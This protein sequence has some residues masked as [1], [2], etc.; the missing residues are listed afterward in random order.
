MAR[1]ISAEQRQR[2]EDDF[3]RRHGFNVWDEGGFVHGQTIEQQAEDVRR[4]KEREA[5]RRRRRRVPRE[6]AGAYERSLK[7]KER[8]QRRR[9]DKYYRGLDTY[10]DFVRDQ[11]RQD[12]GYWERMRDDALAAYDRGLMD[13]RGMRDRSLD[14][15]GRGMTRWE[16]ALGIERDFLTGIRDQQLSLARELRDAPSTVAEQARIEADRALQQNV[17]MAGAFGGGAVSNFGALANQARTAQGDVLA[18]TSALRASEY[19]NR[20]NQQANILGQ[21]GGTSIDL[22]NLG[23]RDLG[24]QTGYAGFLSDTGLRDLTAGQQYAGFLKGLGTT[25]F[26]IGTSLINREGGILGGLGDVLGFG[27]RGDLAFLDR[28]SQIPGMYQNIGQQEYDIFSKERAWQDMMDQREAQ[29]ISGLFKGIANIATGG[30]FD[31]IGSLFGGGRSMSMPDIQA[32]RPIGGYSPTFG[33][34][35]LSE[36]PDSVGLFSGRS[37]TFGSY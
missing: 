24:A 35:G 36:R 21:A 31:K 13:Y 9:E 20:L 27:Q 22:A 23:I 15:Y 10:A 6:K 16:D 12:R 32:T 8:E 7:R 1:A 2:V 28:E 33:S 29:R 19:A 30:I 26:D 18:R 17:A 11:S 3:I 14:Q 37:P 34:Y 4:R 25:N 5:E